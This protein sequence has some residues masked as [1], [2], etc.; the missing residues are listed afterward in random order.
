MKTHIKMSESFLMTT[1]VWYKLS[2]SMPFVKSTIKDEPKSENISAAVRSEPSGPNTVS[3]LPS[4]TVNAMAKTYVTMQR[5][6][7]MKP[8]AC[9]ALI[10]PL[11]NVINSGKKFINL[12]MRV[13]LRSRSSLM[14]LKMAV[15]G[16][17]PSSIEIAAMIG[18][19]QDS[20][21]ISKTRK[22]SNKNQ[23]SQK[24]FSFP[25]RATKRTSTSDVKYAQNK[26]STTVL[27]G[28]R[29]KGPSGKGTARL[30]WFH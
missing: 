18:T 11:T 30:L 20:S 13:S 1:S 12:A 21:T 28:S 26:F 7:R 22:V 5:K 10:M 24:Q 17:L 4:C 8:T 14:L 25:F 9:V 23:K 2:P 3:G 16:V 27:Y 15:L 29:G 6:R 19:I